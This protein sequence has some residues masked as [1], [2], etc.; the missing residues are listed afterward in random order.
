MFLLGTPRSTKHTNAGL[1]LVV[2]ASKMVLQGLPIRNASVLTLP[3][4]TLLYRMVHLLSTEQPSHAAAPAPPLEQQADL[5]VL[6]R[7]VAGMHTWGLVCEIVMLGIN[8][9]Y[10][11]NLRTARTMEQRAGSFVDDVI[12]LAC[13]FFLTIFSFAVNLVGAFLQKERTTCEITATHCMTC[14]N[15]S[16]SND[17]LVGAGTLAACRAC[18]MS[19][20]SSTS[21]VSGFSDSAV[22]HGLHLQP[23]LCY[24]VAYMPIKPFTKLLLFL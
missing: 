14:D 4:R 24:L 5:T 2:D 12:F 23:P 15:G 18:G 10:T 7:F 3:E 9:V 22:M 19:L 20:A 21:T 17:S 6:C 11:L 8:V 13:S 16:P 1:S